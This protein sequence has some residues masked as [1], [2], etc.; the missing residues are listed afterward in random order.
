M[1]MIVLDNTAFVSGFNLNIA[2]SQ[3]DVYF[4]TTPEI[5]IEAENNIKS[6]QFIS[7]AL[8]QNQLKIQSPES[9]SLRE[10]KKSAK[11]TGDLG[12]LSVADL[13]ILGLAY[14]LQANYPQD[15]VLLFSD[16][17]SV[18]NTATSLNIRF[19]ALHKDGISK[20]ITWQ[21]Y[22]PQCYRKYS[23]EMLGKECPQCGGTLKRKRAKQKK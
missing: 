14:E 3:G 12:A 2:S 18:Q 15:E 21:T 4:F 19:Q 16:D 7:I 20:A 1:Q 6:S 22:C 8:M 11:E 23:P 10:V 5:I 13:S 9:T 17:Y